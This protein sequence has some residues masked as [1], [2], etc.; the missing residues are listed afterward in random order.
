MRAGGRIWKFLVASCC[1]IGSGIVIALYVALSQIGFVAESCVPFTVEP[2]VRSLKPC[3]MQTCFNYSPCM[4]T[5]KVKIFIYPKIKMTGGEFLDH[6][7]IPY[8]EFIGTIRSLPWIE[9]TSNPAEACL[10]FPYIQDLQCFGQC[11]MPANPN[12]LRTLSYWNNGK[13]HVIFDHVDAA[14]PHY[15]T[16][17]AILI[18]TNCRRYFCRDLYDITVGQFPLVRAAPP[19]TLQRKY[20]LAFKGT[21]NREKYYRNRLKSLHNGVDVI[22]VLRCDA[23]FWMPILDSTCK[24][25]DEMYNNWDY[26]D[27]LANSTF[28]LVV[29]GVGPHS[30]RLAEILLA[31]NI[32]VFVVDDFIPPIEDI[33]DW[34]TFSIFAS[35]QDINNLPTMLRSISAERIA[36]MR[37]AAAEITR[38][39]FAT[40]SASISGA[41]DVLRNRIGAFVGD[42]A[43][44]AV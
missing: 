5:G 24:D 34:S 30:Y 13:N 19:S 20:L 40:W 33:I 41:M 2:L 16:D 23:D 10:L 38:K 21:R 17:E 3:S 1:I 22:M 11:S 15:E 37:L 18:R 44:D 39:Y 25:E 6:G 28:G 36:E 31:G 42:I 12:F 29:E 14:V 7:I 4:A 9:E 27:L 8:D 26:A 35:P 43:E 32:P